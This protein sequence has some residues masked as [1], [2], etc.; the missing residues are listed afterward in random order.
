MLNY[1]QNRF[2]LS[3]QGARDFL[4]GTFSTTILNLMLIF[5]SAYFYYF[6]TKYL[7]PL[8]TGTPIIY[9][10]MLRFILLSLG[11]LI[12]TYFVARWQYKNTFFA[13]YSESSNRRIS[14]AEKLR[15][16]PLAF[17]NTKNLSD[18]TST[19]MEDSTDLEH[20][21]SHTVPQI[22]ASIISLTLISFGL[23]IYNWQ[24]ALSIFWVIPFS[25][26][27]LMISKR[28]QHRDNHKIYLNKREVS[29]CIQ[30]G[31][32]NVYEIK[33]YGQEEN[34]I[35]EL[36]SKLNAY[37][38]ILLKGELMI[39]AIVHGAQ[40]FLKLGI[41]SVILVGAHLLSI[42]SIDL[43]TYI[44]Y[45]VVVARIYN[46][47][48]EALSNIAALFFLDIRI[49]RMRKMQDLP[50]QTGLD[51]CQPDTFSI[52][53]DNVHFSYDDGTKVLKGTSFTAKQG[54]VTAL[55]GPSGSGKTTA[56][57]LAARFWDIDAGQIFLGDIDISTVSPETL[58]KHYSVVF[59]DVVLFNTSI[60][61]NI[62]IGKQD[63]TEEEIFKAAKL[64]QCE[65]FISKLPEQ[66]QTVIG[67]NGQT[68]SGGERQR[69]SIARAILKDAPIILLDEATASLDVE[70]E[71][72]VQKSLSTLIKDKTVII[73]AHRMRTIASADHIVILEDGKVKDQGTPEYLIA[74]GGMYAK[75]LS[76]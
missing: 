45:L 52:K 25:F 33:S 72:K 20:I 60:M 61:D 4:K 10:G 73:I 2:S 53:F 32:E 47:L 12:T 7:Q 17:F 3:E 68:L 49:E 15:I 67:E 46:P 19:I 6:L 16:L 50:A 48:D 27:L 58:L 69:I 30:E 14:L 39:G 70:N 65:E 23:F 42:H 37:E 1:I 8:L 54:Q 62:K 71:T 43:F 55:I 13:V 5:P 34:Y 36:Q 11:L 76:M 9:D 21:F 51:K 41:A 64:A 57:K 38:Q 31:L 29:D 74:Q 26:I 56:T 44:L 75:Q 35:N 40:S 63:A 18:L 59:Q 28:K 24:M 66:Y 22:F